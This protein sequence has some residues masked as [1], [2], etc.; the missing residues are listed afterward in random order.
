MVIGRVLRVGITVNSVC[1]VAYHWQ[2]DFSAYW[3]WLAMLRQCFSSGTAADGHTPYK[4]QPSPSWPKNYHLRPCPPDFHNF[5]YVDRDLRRRFDIHFHFAVSGDKLLSQW[6]EFRYSGNW[7]RHHYSIQI[8]FQERWKRDLE[9]GEVG[10]EDP[11]S[12][13]VNQAALAAQDIAKAVDDKQL[14]EKKDANEQTGGGHGTR[15][16][17]GPCGDGSYSG[18]YC[19]RTIYSTK[20]NFKRKNSLHVHDN[21]IN[22]LISEIKQCT[23]SDVFLCLFISRLWLCCIVKCYFNIIHIYSC[24]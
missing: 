11:Q 8:L 21:W 17:E 22:I 23:E 18:S 19:L 7:W 1:L 4:I 20:S 9:C 2:M 16:L 3:M 13:R 14:G 12:H 15:G 6:T 24:P 5:L 10:H